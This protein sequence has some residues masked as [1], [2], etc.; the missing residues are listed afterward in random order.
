MITT[1][2]LTG[3]LATLDPGTFD[4]DA[5]AVRLTELQYDI[6]GDG[7]LDTVTFE[8][9][10]TLVVATDV[11]GDG[12]ADHVTMV[13]GAGGYAAWEFHRDAD[14]GHRWEQVDD[15]RLDD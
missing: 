15:G 5:D 6:D 8:A 2:E 9:G 10:D 12:D 14:G 7:I 13:G 11:D 3:D 1:D 4:T